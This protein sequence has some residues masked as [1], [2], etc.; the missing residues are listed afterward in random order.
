MSPPEQR[1]ALYGLNR[2]F[3]SVSDI[4]NIKGLLLLSLNVRSLLPKINCLRIDF[5]CVKFDFFALCE[6]WLFVKAEHC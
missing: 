1:A 2:E 6:T 4:A 5:S 3:S